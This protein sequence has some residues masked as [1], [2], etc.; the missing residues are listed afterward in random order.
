MATVLIR[1]APK[2]QECGKAR[3]SYYETQKPF[4]NEWLEQV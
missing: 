4:M 2:S 3:S 1:G